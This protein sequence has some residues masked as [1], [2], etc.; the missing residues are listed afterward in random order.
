MRRAYLCPV[1][2][3]TC[4]R[5]GRRRP[6]SSTLVT[7]VI[8]GTM[9]AGWGIWQGLKALAHVFTHDPSLWIFPVLAVIAVVGYVLIMANSS[10][11]KNRERRGE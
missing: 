8:V 3:N 1:H 6:A 11:I 4:C 5:C 2:R 10:E 9:I 7:P